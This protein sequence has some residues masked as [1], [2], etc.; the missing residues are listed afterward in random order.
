V[1]ERAYQQALAIAREQQARSLELRAAMSLA[2]LWQAEE[3]PQRAYQLLSSIY[4]WFTEGR[5]TSDL[6]EARDLL[7]QLQTNNSSYR[8]RR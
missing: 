2:R 3:Q 6:I 5:N 4:G 1:V 8:Q 7:E